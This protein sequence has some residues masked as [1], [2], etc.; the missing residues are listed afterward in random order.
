MSW[1]PLLSSP[2][3]SSIELFPPLCD[4][5]HHNPVSMAASSVVRSALLLPT[6]P[7]GHDTR[8]VIRPTTLLRFVA[9]VA[10]K[11]VA[12]CFSISHFSVLLLLL[13]VSRCEIRL[14]PI[15]QEC[16]ILMPTLSTYQH[17]SMRVQCVPTRMKRLTRTCRRSRCHARRMIP[18]HIPH[19]DVHLPL[20][21]RARPATEGAVDG[22]R[23]F[24]GSEDAARRPPPRS[25]V[26]WRKRNEYLYISANPPEGMEGGRGRGK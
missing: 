25:F 13:L 3:L 7:N 12:R 20:E 23:G 16:G 2:L 17:S 21:V 9:S 18:L 22:R 11:T 26:R 24:P 15:R 5:I 8:L 4:G 14:S 1:S 19:Y 6:D 10:T